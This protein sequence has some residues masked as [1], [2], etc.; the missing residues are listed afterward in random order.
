MD[1]TAEPADGFSLAACANDVLHR[2]PKYGLITAMRFLSR[3]LLSVLLCLVLPLQAS[4]GLV[5]AVT[6]MAP[7]HHA[8]L[9]GDSASPQASMQVA[10]AIGAAHQHGAHAHHEKLPKQKAGKAVPASHK[11]KHAKGECPSC[12]KCCLLAAVAPPPAFTRES[13]IPVS[14]VAFVAAA[15]SIPSFLPDGPERPPRS[16]LA[17]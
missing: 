3:T 6:M 12:A 11:A 14:R 9:H 4:A 5:R 13:S 1:V 10:H 15:L 16:S 8:Q 17:T 2:F 7:A